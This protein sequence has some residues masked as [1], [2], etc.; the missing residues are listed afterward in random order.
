MEQQ[1]AELNSLRDM[2]RNCICLL[3]I[4]GIGLFYEFYQ[5]KSLDDLLSTDSVVFGKMDQLLVG[6]KY[7]IISRFLSP[8]FV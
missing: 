1:F 6:Q 4:G 8:F 7:R 3:E 5:N 2:Y